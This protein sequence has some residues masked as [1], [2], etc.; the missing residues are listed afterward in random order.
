MN[1]TATHQLE[2]PELEADI[3]Y[4]SAQEGGRHSAVRNGYSGQFF[5]S[6]Q[7]WDATQQ[8][9]DKAICNPG[10]AVLVY[11]QTASP[12]CHVGHLFVGQEFEIREG[13]RTVG[14]GKITKILREDF[15]YWDGATFLKSLD[16]NIAPYSS[17]DD[18]HV[19]RV[20]LE[21]WLNKTEILE[22][23]QF[24]MTGN[25][26]CMMIIRCKLVDQSL[27]PK[28]VANKMIECWQEK[29]A[30]ANQFYKIKWHN[31]TFILIFATWHSMFLTGQIIRLSL[32]S[33]PSQFFHLPPSK[34]TQNLS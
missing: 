15:N 12:V 8:F 4:M 2:Q 11:L 27:Q 24:E 30:Q 25:L 28:K 17:D 29:L 32:T 20:D 31:D 21:R 7:N 5:Y 6:G 18:L 19:L 22:D 26:E 1:Y 10:E 14:K 9:L 33:S 16:K 34:S 13:G 3:Y 23:V